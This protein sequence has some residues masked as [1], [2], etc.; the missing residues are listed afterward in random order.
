MT[1]N[2]ITVPTIILRGHAE[3]RNL[4]AA[5]AKQLAARKRVQQAMRK[6]E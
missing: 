2:R 6:G 5:R 4:E 3:Q 1:V